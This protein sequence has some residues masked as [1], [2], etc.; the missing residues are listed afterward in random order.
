ML[1]ISGMGAATAKASSVIVAATCNAVIPAP[2]MTIAAR[3]HQ[4]CR[5]AAAG[6]KHIAPA[7]IANRALRIMPF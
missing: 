1:S 6:R 4:N 5:I 7:L 2:R 3:K